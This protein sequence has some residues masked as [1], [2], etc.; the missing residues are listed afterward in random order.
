[1]GTDWTS[2]DGGSGDDEFR[3]NEARVT[4][5]PLSLGRLTTAFRG[6]PE[7]VNGRVRP[8]QQN[9]RTGICLDPRGRRSVG[10]DRSVAVWLAVDWHACRR[11]ARMISCYGHWLHAARCNIKRSAG[12]IQMCVLI[13]LLCG[14]VESTCCYF[15][16]FANVNVCYAVGSR[17]SGLRTEATHRSCHELRYAPISWKRQLDSSSS[18]SITSPP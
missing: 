10:T 7:A 11:L 1:M 17:C 18:V 3:E 14:N 13:V 12:V 9:A 8:W 5:A 2:V 6:R 4:P 16:R 15:Q